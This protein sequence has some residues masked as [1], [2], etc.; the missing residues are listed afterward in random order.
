MAELCEH[1]S[2][3]WLHT[4]TSLS[5]PQLQP[6]VQEIAIKEAAPTAGG[7]GPWSQ[8]NLLPSPLAGLWDGAGSCCSSCVKA[9]NGFGGLSVSAMGSV[10]S[11]VRVL[12]V[13]RLQGV[14]VHR[15][16]TDLFLE[17]V[18]QA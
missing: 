15:Y 3:C 14:I 6:M 5:L 2:E 18:L 8:P 12:Y 4:S 9:G 1:I 17:L 7:V 10:Y 11:A 16:E 13:P